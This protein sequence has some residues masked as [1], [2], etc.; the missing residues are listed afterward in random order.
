MGTRE[1]LKGLDYDQLHYARDCADDL[2]KA[3]DA[4]T[5]VLVWV[6]STDCRNVGGFLEHD[7]QKAVERAHLAVDLEAKDGTGFTIQVE[8]ERRRESEVPEMLTLDI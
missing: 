1:Y 6:V 5:R 7:Y 8:A 3:K 2:I 4:E